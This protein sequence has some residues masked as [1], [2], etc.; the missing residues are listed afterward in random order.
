MAKRKQEKPQDTALELHVMTNTE[1]VVQNVVMPYAAVGGGVGAKANILTPD[2]LPKAMVASANDEGRASERYA[3]WDWIKGILDKTEQVETTANA[4]EYNVRALLGQDVL[5]VKKLDMAQG[6]SNVQRHYSAEIEAFLS[7]NFIREEFLVGKANDLCTVFNGFSECI[8]NVSRSKIVQVAWKE[9][10]FSRVEQFSK[11]KGTFD[12]KNLYYSSMFAAGELSDSKLLDPSLT[13]IIPLFNPLNL[14][15]YQDAIKAK[16]E[17]FAVH[18]RP[19]TSRSFHYARAPWMALYKDE[20]W[21]DAAGNVP[22]IVNAMQTNQICLRYVIYISQKYLETWVKVE[23]GK[24]YITLTA[25]E[26][27]EQFD[28]LTKKIQDKLVGT[29]N[30]WSTLSLLALQDGMG[31]FIKPILIEPVDDKTKSG[32]WVPDT[33]HADQHIYRGHQLSTSMLGL[34]NSNVKMNSTS[35]S[36]TRE[37]FNT[38]VTLNTYLQ[39]LLLMELQMIADFNFGNGW[40]EWDVQFFV[41]D[42]SHTTTNNVENGLKPSGNGTQIGN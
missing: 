40:S 33:D 31:N 11:S 39:R 12:R 41:D 5:Y 24:D 6:K 30:V 19:R 8:F 15:W 38:V 42:M 35:G 1:G 25:K 4:I 34:S 32:T 36:D 23:T 14:T 9:A 18:T 10:E 26:K 13:T 20:G 29:K 37:G 21:V 28:A 17:K 27:K 22:I 16:Y 2:D 7:R 3:R